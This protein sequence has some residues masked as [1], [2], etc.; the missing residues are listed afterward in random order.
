MRVQALFAI[1]ANAATST[2]NARRFSTAILRPGVL[3]LTRQ[4]AAQ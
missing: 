3:T 1:T 2:M 4:R